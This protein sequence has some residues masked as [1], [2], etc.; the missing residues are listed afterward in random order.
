MKG[1]LTT[2]L[3][4]QFVEESSTPT[5]APSNKMKGDVGWNVLIGYPIFNVMSARENRVL[6]RRGRTVRISS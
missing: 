2:E 4:G 3:P 1:A 6:P 5:T